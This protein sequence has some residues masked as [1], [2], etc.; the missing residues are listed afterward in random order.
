MRLGKV[1][2]TVDTKDVT[3]EQIAN[4]MVG[5]E[6]FLDIKKPQILRGDKRMTVKDLTYVSE[7]G[8][9]VLKGGFQFIFR[10]SFRHC[11]CR[12]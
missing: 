9:P 5:R 7:T 1:I 6:V 4:M 3:K 2:G 10:R 12:R 8:R 11:R